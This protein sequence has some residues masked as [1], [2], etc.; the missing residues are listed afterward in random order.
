M[1]QAILAA[2]DAAHIRCLVQEQ[3]KIETEEFQMMPAAP[4]EILSIGGIRLDSESHTVTSFG[5]PANLTPSEFDLLHALMATP[6]RVFSRSEL[7]LKMESGEFEN[8]ER[9]VDVHIRNL[10]TKIEPAA[11]KPIYIKTVFGIG[12]RF[13]LE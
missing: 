4:L 8:A 9:T 6:G 10:R 1:T 7:L 2:D 3:L 12:Y 13:Q 5:R 11:S